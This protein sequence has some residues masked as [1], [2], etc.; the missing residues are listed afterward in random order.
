MDMVKRI[1]HEVIKNYH[2]LSQEEKRFS[3]KVESDMK[4]MDKNYD[5]LKK[6]NDKWFSKL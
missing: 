5:D 4:K 1:V 6:K 3:K 2:N